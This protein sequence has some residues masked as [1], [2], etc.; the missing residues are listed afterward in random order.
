MAENFDLNI[1]RLHPQSSKIVP[2]EKTLNGTANESGV[3]FCKPFSNANS[4][5]WWIY[6]AVDVDIMYT[7]TGFE[8]KLLESYP[9]TER[10]ILQSLVR[11]EDNIN[12]DEFCPATPEGRSKFTWG[13]VEP[14]VVQMWT[15]CIFETPPGWVLHIKSPNNIPPRGFWVMEGI[16]ETDWMRYDIWTNLIFETKNEWIHIRKNEWPPIAQI[17]PI[18]REGIE[19]DWKINTN[20]LINR[21]TEN[22]N[23]VFDYW[24]QYNQEKFGKGGK[25]N[26]L[27]DGSKTK[28][29]TT[30]FRE[31][32]RI[33]KNQ[34]EPN[35]EEKSKI[36]GCP[37]GHQP[38][39]PSKPKIK[40]RFY[41]PKNND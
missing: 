5:G 38:T 21:D 41:K 34:M 22:A 1:W 16:L 28:D 7:D 4:A 30:Y 12:L 2:A 20:E 31:K 26:M 8:Y 18:R 6:P 9:P 35:E 19:G 36:R 14:N 37:F 25:Q 15:G 33:L 24:I 23:E 13:A 10:T 11:P 39:E 32:K 17:M 3:K 40:N 29:S 27:P